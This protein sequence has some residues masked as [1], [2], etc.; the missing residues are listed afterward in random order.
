MTSEQKNEGPMTCAEFQE[1]MPELYGA[2]HSLSAHEHVQNCENCAALV[3]DLEYIAEQ[4]RFLLPIHDPSPKV[5][6]NISASIFPEGSSER[7]EDDP[8]RVRRRTRNLGR[9]RRCRP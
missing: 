4:A 8:R 7:G 1:H 3:R 2:G 9:F 5:W 6:E